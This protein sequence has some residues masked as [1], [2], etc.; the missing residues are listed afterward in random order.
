MKHLKNSKASKKKIFRQIQHQT[1]KYSL[2]KEK[3][4]ASHAEQNLTKKKPKREKREK[5]K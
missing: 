2:L 1:S 5:K 4:N 3:K